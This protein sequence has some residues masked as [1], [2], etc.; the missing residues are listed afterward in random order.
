M[1]ILLDTHIYLWVVMDHPKLSQEARRLILDADEVFISSASIWEIA[2]KVSLGKIDANV[3]Q[4][5]Q[6]IQ[7]CGF[8]ELPI[9]ATHAAAVRNLPDYH[10]DP[11]DRILVAQA[12]CEPLRLLSADARVRKYSDLVITV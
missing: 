1:K 9:R 5:V 8:V 3:E 6:E 4:L 2:I 10:R 12:L 7:N 11:F